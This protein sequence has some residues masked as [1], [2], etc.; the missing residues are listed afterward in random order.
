MATCPRYTVIF[1]LSVGENVDFKRNERSSQ[2]RRVMVCYWVCVSLGVCVCLVCLFFVFLCGFIPFFFL[3]CNYFFWFFLCLYF[4]HIYIL[5]FFCLT[6]NIFCVYINSM[7]VYQ[8]IYFVIFIGL[9]TLFFVYSFIMFL[10][11][12]YSLCYVMIYTVLFRFSLS[13]SSFH[14]IIHSYH[15]ASNGVEVYFESIVDR[16]L[17]KLLLFRLVIDS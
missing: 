8:C 3:L 15:S 16:S 12:I 7:F 13:Y 14:L 9:F 4:F 5:F 6:F 10:L 1:L 2:T 11:F 17:M